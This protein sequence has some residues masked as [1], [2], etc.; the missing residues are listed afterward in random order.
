MDTYFAPAGRDAPEDLQR[1]VA[2][3]QNTPPLQ[4][5]MD[6]LPTPVVV[7]NKN[8]QILAVNRALLQMLNVD[9]DEVIGRRT[10]EVMGCTFSKGG[11]DGCG[12][13]K[14]CLTCGAVAAVLESWQ[15][16][17]PVTRECRLTLDTAIDGG[18]RDLKVTATALEV[19]DELL[20]VCT[21]EDIS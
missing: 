20:T 17:S 21:I 13:T 2:L 8:R 12:T 7:L 6:A 15:T 9:V 16:R 11:P 10:G 5:I 14:Y 1:R 18:A 4:M 19:S 3:V